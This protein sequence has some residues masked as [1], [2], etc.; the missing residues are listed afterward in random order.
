MPP[1]KTAPKKKAP[2]APK[3]AKPASKSQA[4]RVKAQADAPAAVEPQKELPTVRGHKVVRIIEQNDKF[5]HCE[6]DDGTTQ[7]VASE[8]F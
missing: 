1:K 3:A 5:Y 8:L 7:H 2:K 6:M 4:R